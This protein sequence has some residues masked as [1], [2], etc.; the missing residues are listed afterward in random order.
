LPQQ[1]RRA[2]TAAAASEP[3][4]TATGD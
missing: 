2:L 4:P 3:T 1:L